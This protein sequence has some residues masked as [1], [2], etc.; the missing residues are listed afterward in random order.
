M[1]II[2][3]QNHWRA[4][5]IF[6]VKRLVV[7]ALF[8]EDMKRIAMIVLALLCNAANAQEAQPTGRTVESDYMQTSFWLDD[9]GCS[10]K[11]SRLLESAPEIV[12][13]L[14][15]ERSRKCNVTITHK[16]SYKIIGK[17]FH[18]ITRNSYDTSVGKIIV[19]KK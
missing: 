18:I 1:E 2:A 9:L 13:V 16:K 5:T 4:R 6:V 8:G 14:F 15:L 11:N 19:E 10:E 7:Q 3:L 17:T 12:D